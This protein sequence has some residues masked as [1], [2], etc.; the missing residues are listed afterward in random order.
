MIVLDIYKPKPVPFFSSFVEKYGL[1]IFSI[2]SSAIPPALSLI[3][4]TFLSV[5]IVMSGFFVSLSSRNVFNY[6][7]YITIYTL[8]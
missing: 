1:N 2:I 4:K 7:A 6:R 3:V 5:L 8:F